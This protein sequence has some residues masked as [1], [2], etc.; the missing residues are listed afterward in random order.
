LLHQYEHF[1]N[2]L[3]G[4]SYISEDDIAIKL[5]DKVILNIKPVF[6][7]IAKKIEASKY[8]LDFKDDW[9]DEGSLAYSEIVW[10][11]TVK[12]IISYAEFILNTSKKILEAPEIYHGPNGT[13]DVLWEAKTKFQLL[14]NVKEDGFISFYGDDFKNQK[15]EG[16]FL[17]TDFQFSLLPFIVFNF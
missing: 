3:I 4:W 11:H 13:I 6:S 12:F 10:I 14:L 15:L 8:I 17:S 2:H 7:S 9:D 16:V 1:R 5:N